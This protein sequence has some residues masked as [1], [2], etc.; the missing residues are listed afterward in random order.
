MASTHIRTSCT[1]CGASLD[2]PAT[3]VIVQLPSYHEP[4][5]SPVLLLCCPACSTSG[6][7]QIGWRT[8]AYLLEEGT[9]C[10]VAPEDDAV[11]P[12][13]PEQLPQLATPMSLDD[14]IDLNDALDTDITAS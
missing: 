1:A 13:H 8:A 6:I 4:L 5:I 2:A 12:H 10:V 11:R 9:T 7:T 14:L 3:R